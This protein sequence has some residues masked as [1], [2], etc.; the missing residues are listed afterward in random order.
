MPWQI[1]KNF[2]NDFFSNKEKMGDNNQ[3]VLPKIHSSTGINRQ[4]KSSN[5]KS[6]IIIDLQKEYDEDLEL[7]QMLNYIRKLI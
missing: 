4:I 7:L 1:A 6:S 5:G 2:P 3:F